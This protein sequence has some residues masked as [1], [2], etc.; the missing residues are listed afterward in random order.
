[1]HR[2]LLTLA[3]ALSILFGT[4]SLNIACLCTTPVEYTATEAVGVECHGEQGDV[5]AGGSCCCADEGDV[6]APV[7]DAAPAGTK[8]RPCPCLYWTAVPLT[9]PESSTGPSLVKRVME[10]SPVLLLEAAP[11]P[12]ASEA[13]VFSRAGPSGPRDSSTRAQAWLCVWTI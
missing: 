7:D 13:A 5:D 2:V 12:V 3:T 9:T 8:P 1:M 10:F 4:G 11:A 6:P